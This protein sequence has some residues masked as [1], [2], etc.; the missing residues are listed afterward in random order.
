M[1]LSCS[2]PAPLSTP[3]QSDFPPLARL[4]FRY[5]PSVHST[6]CQIDLPLL[7]NKDAERRRPACRIAG[8][9]N[10]TSS[11]T[12]S[13]SSMTVRP[14]AAPSKSVR[15]HTRLIRRG[16]PSERLWISALALSEKIGVG[17]PARTTPWSMY[18]QVSLSDKPEN[19]TQWRILW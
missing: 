3:C 9:T 7:A 14:C 6:S 11:E 10:H 19:S 15:R 8:K 18:S 12:I 13:A 5:T 1:S 17:L 2:P 4:S 16:M